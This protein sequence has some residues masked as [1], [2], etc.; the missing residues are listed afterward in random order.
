[1]L[2][3]LKTKY[4]TNIFHKIVEMI[5]K[6]KIRT[7]LNDVIKK[8]MRIKD[9][10]VCTGYARIKKERA[11]LW[12]LLLEIIKQ[13]YIECSSFFFDIAVYDES[14]SAEIEHT[15]FI[16]ICWKHLVP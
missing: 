2:F 14:I 8:E 5:L 6:E 1:M 16:K 10:A 3:I 12:L 9:Y 7:I 11:R 15:N 4:K 13:L